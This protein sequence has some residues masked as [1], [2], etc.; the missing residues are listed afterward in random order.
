VNVAAPR[1]AGQGEFVPLLRNVR[2]NRIVAVVPERLETRRLVLRAWQDADRDA[3]AALHAG[4][5]R[6]FDD[7]LAHWRT[8]GFGAWAVER[9]DGDGRP[10]VGLT[11]L[12]VPSFLS[13][14]LPAAEVVWH[15]PPAWRGAGLATEAARAALACAWRALG[16]RRVLCVV[17]PDNAASLRVAQ[18]LGMRAGADRVLP[19][20]GERVRVFELD[21]PR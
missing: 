2:E 20:T 19:R 18:K 11:G 13:A 15:V 6:L 5:D 21:A 4:S 14:V 8:H 1:E 3:F 17:R 10:G 16:M 9:R 7:V 12:V